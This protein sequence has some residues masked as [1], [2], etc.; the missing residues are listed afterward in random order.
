MPLSPAAESAIT[1]LFEKYK[2]RFPDA[3]AALDEIDHHQYEGWFGK[4]RLDDEDLLKFAVGHCPE[5]LP[6]LIKSGLDPQVRFKAAHNE[7]DRTLLDVALSVH[8]SLEWIRLLVTCGCPVEGLPLPEEGWTDAP[9]TRPP[10][11]HAMSPD[12]SRCP[13]LEWMEGM[14]GLGFDLNQPNGDGDFLLAQVMQNPVL[15]PLVPWMLDHGAFLPDWTQNNPLALLSFSSRWSAGI[16]AEAAAARALVE[17][18]VDTGRVPLTEPLASRF[19]SSALWSSQASPLAAPVHPRTVLGE[20]ALY[21]GPKGEVDAWCSRM[22]DHGYPLNGEPGILPPLLLVAAQAQALPMFEAVLRQPGVDL[23]AADIAF[24]TVNDCLDQMEEEQGNHV[25]QKFR[26][27]LE[28]VRS[29]QVLEALAE[30]QPAL[31]RIRL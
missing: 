31:P 27:A 19:V 16:L 18:L 5:T 14:L 11:F 26:D 30:G 12:A 7:G 20:P 15:Y 17:T 1:A 4:A 6:V 13:T 23:D 25:A 3:R 2:D 29:R 24:N 21:M 10:L 9:W 22:L 28:N 8:A